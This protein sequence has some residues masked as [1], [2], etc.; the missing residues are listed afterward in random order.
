M[1]GF[2]GV[3][4][5][6]RSGLSFGTRS[7]CTRTV[8]VTTEEVIFA[9]G[10]IRAAKHVQKKAT[11]KHMDRR[12]KKTRPSDRNRKP[13]PYDVDPLHAEGMPP[14]YTV[15]GF[16]DEEEKPIEVVEQFTTISSDP[17]LAKLMGKEVVALPMDPPIKEKK[18]PKKRKW[19]RHAKRNKVVEPAA[20]QADEPEVKAVAEASAEESV[21]EEV[22]KEAETTAK[23]A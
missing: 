21:V 22:A 12:P 20:A 18:P 4:T 17:Y 23:T 3:A 15:L 11:K 13:V 2:C 19:G 9:P 8:P 5:L 6:P 1:Y 16:L 10:E 14:E 7:V